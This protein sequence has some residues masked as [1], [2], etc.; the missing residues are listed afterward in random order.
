M[1]L[2]SKYQ[3]LARIDFISGDEFT[4]DT[5]QKTEFEGLI[6]A[7]SNSNTFINGKNSSNIAGILMTDI[8]TVITEGDLIEEIKTGYRYIVSGSGSQPLGV[9]GIKPKR[10]Q[11]AEYSLV[12]NNKGV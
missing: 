9:T 4:P 6:Q 8:S 10:G 7:P 1:S 11:H 5:E 2:K 12:F 3:K